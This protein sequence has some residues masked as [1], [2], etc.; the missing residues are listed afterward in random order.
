[1]LNVYR[2]KIDNGWYNYYL[3]YNKNQLG[4]VYC[5]NGDL[6]FCSGS[7]SYQES[8]FCITKENMSIYNLFSSLFNNFKNCEMFHVDDIK[9]SFCENEQEI[10]EEYERVSKFNDNLRNS[11]IYKELFDGKTI[12]W[13]SDDSVSFDYQSADAMKITKEDEYFKLKFTYYENEFP[14]ARSIRIRNARSRYKPFNVFMMDFYNHLQ[15]YD[16]D[17][18][19]VHMEEYLFNQDMPKK[20]IKK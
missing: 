14:Y 7:K 16:P 6:Y 3:S 11:S 18:H 12:T 9:L 17:C 5:D 2:N 8:D 1:M 20:L 13:I 10:K 4:I 19:Q 15:E